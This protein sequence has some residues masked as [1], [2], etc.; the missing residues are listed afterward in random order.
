MMFLY[1]LG[2]VFA[3]LLGD[4]SLKHY[5]R[6]LGFHHLLFGIMGYI[7]V[8]VLLI[9]SLT[10]GT[11]L[12]VNNGWNAMNSIIENGY[13]YFILG[14]RLEPEQYCGIFFIVIGIYFL[15]I[16]PCKL[17]SRKELETFF[18]FG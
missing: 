13:A 5:A 1:I 4:V 7:C 17:P 14:E 15:K 3:E 18:G 6:G 2:L 16:F 9:L 8:I 12:I 10:N 11:I